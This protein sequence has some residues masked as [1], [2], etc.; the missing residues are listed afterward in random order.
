MAVNDRQPYQ[1][2]T[3]R[4]LGNMAEV[5]LKSGTPPDQNQISKPGGGG[6]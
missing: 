3:V 4:Q 1:P 6:G 2:P 5:T